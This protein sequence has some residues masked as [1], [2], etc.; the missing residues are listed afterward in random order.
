M[1]GIAAIG[2]VVGLSTLGMTQGS[3][4]NY[5]DW[6]GPE[7]IYPLAQQAR[8]FINAERATNSLADISLDH[9]L[10]GVAWTHIPHMD[11]AYNGQVCASHMYCKYGPRMWDEYSPTDGSVGYS[12]CCYLEDDSVN[13]CLE[14]RAE[15][16]APFIDS[17]HST[18]Y[19][20]SWTNVPVRQIAT[21]GVPPEDD[22]TCDPTVL[23][24]DNL[25]AALGS[26]D[27]SP[28]TNGDAVSMGLNVWGYSITI[29]YVSAADLSS[30][31]VADPTV[32]IDPIVM[33]ATAVPVEGE[34]CGTWKINDLE[35]I[36]IEEV[37]GARKDNYLAFLPISVGLLEVAG[38]HAQDYYRNHVAS[39]DMGAYQWSDNL[40]SADIG[41]TWSKCCTEAS[42]AATCLESKAEEI[43]GGDWKGVAATPHLTFSSEDIATKEDVKAVLL[44]ILAN[45]ENAILDPAAVQMG[46]AIRKNIVTIYRSRIMVSDL[47]AGEYDESSTSTAGAVIAGIASTPIAIVAAAV[48]SM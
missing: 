6:E 25:E 39:C 46:V 5:W 27:L 36:L 33:P 32:V 16:V 44:S 20:S 15:D 14:K 17:L 31:G 13:N 35:K 37:N 19:S 24:S 29:F 28:I 41:V 10:Q 18:S 43:V 30:A 26:V 12:G 11:E 45:D 1:V 40:D 9:I 21:R 4:S 34:V 23:T 42:D 2:A 47:C 8:D 3:S 48:A 22:T 38:L 7:R